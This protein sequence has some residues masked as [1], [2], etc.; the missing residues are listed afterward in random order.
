MSEKTFILVGDIKYPG[1]VSV[2]AKSLEEAVHKAERGDFE[3][4]DKTSKCL[5]FEWNGDQD[6]VE[7]ED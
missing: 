2:R 6:T 4:Y 5:D 1:R 3:V 7:R